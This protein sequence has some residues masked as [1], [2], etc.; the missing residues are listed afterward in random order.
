MQF[1]CSA[2]QHEIWT[3]TL[4]G[5]TSLLGQI[6]SALWMNWKPAI[7][8]PNF[9]NINLPWVEQNWAIRQTP[10]HHAN[11]ILSLFSVVCI[12]VFICIFTH[13]EHTGTSCQGIELRDND[14][15]WTR[16]I[17]FSSWN[18]DV[19]TSVQWVH[20]QQLW[21][22]TAHCRLCLLVAEVLWMPSNSLVVSM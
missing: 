15:G 6:R 19:G 14:Y 17:L 10:V 2:D 18:I 13:T 12:C 21:C 8:F 11:L 20:P 4:R 7:C 3:L 16:H 1:K 22:R 9:L 5:N